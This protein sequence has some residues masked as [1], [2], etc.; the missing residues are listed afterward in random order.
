MKTSV[1]CLFICMSKIHN[2][3]FHALVHNFTD[4]ILKVFSITAEASVHISRKMDTVCLFAQSINVLRTET[5][6][7]FRDHVRSQMFGIFSDIIH[8][9][10]RTA[11]DGEKDDFDFQTIT[12]RFFGP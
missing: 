3:G 12:V 11:R 4:K 2:V 10:R 6:H 1:C 7:D 9:M 5:V 8:D